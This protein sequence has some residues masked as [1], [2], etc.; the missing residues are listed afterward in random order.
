MSEPLKDAEI[1]PEAVQTEEKDVPFEERFSSVTDQ[2]V[3]QVA[4]DTAEEPEA[5]EVEK[6]AQEYLGDVE[7]EAPA[8]PAISPE[9]AEVRGQVDLLK[10]QII[11]MG[12]AEKVPEPE[13]GFDVSVLDDPSVQAHLAAAKE[14][15][16]PNAM[17]K[18]LAVIA[19]HVYEAQGES[20]VNTEVKALKEELAD[21]KKTSQE[22]TR[23]QQN[24]AMFVEGLKA[25]A[26]L[27]QSEYELAKDFVEKQEL[28]SWNDH[29]Q[30]HGATLEGYKPKSAYGKFL[31]Q[32]PEFMAT[33]KLM[34]AG[35]RLFV[36]ELG[37]SGPS[38]AS[39]VSK[40]AASAPVR[41][42]GIED[43]GGGDKLTPEQQILAGIKAAA[44]R[45]NKARAFR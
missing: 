26:S 36:S 13:G 32:N 30:R 41:G 3:E 31:M 28:E 8:A 24:Q 38:V 45:R 4:G 35:M 19:Q 9:L 40:T 16:D 5:S 14:S 6:A 29:I 1:A 21:L 39:P 18:A 23:R 2:E 17:A 33:P 37:L 10:D 34:K 20:K 7:Q 15:D 22:T 12:R 11:Q 44:A 43:T 27:G 42:G 25:A